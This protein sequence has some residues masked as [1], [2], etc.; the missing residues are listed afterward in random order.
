MLNYKHRI[1]VFDCAI[2][3]QPVTTG[4]L[5]ASQLL[6]V[7]PALSP[8]EPSD[9][10]VTY[11]RLG[12]E[13]AHR[14]DESTGLQLLNHSFQ[15]ARELDGALKHLVLGLDLGKSRPLSAPSEIARASCWG[16]SLH[17]L[18]SRGVV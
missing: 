15:I 1:S 17:A 2:T 9:C 14:G 13:V 8:D 5:Q 11:A 18:D 10:G 3:P 7:Y 4:N 6:A 16:A 12:S